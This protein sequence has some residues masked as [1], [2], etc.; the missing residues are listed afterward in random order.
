M[1]EE[2]NDTIKVNLQQLVLL[3]SLCIG[4]VSLAGAFF[5]L[6]YRVQ[7]VEEDVTALKAK[8]AAIEARTRTL[9]TIITKLDTLLEERRER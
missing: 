7:R 3:I 8:D 9:E 5:L 6:P 2:S 4:I 1:P